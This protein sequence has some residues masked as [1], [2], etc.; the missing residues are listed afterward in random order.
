M[1]CHSNFSP[2]VGCRVARVLRLNN[3]NILEY[4][5]HIYMRLKF[6]L[7]I[8]IFT[9]FKFKNKCSV[10]GILAFDACQSV[11]WICTISVWFVFQKSMNPAGFQ[12]KKN[13]WIHIGYFVVE[14]A[15]IKD[16]WKILSWEKCKNAINV[17]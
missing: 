12:K 13:L 4:I 14:Y 1:M 15:G 2:I 8:Q 11:K 5:M 16:F 7:E 6:G 17:Q 9:Y 3:I 10:G